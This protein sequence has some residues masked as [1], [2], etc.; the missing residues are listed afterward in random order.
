MSAVNNN[1]FFEIW[2]G[3]DLPYIRE[4]APELLR[5]ETPPAPGQMPFLRRTDTLP[6]PGQM[7]FLERTDTLPAPGYLP[8]VDATERAPFELPVSKR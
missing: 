7:P 8:R 2:Y 3:E 6:A 1:D 5:I 4:H